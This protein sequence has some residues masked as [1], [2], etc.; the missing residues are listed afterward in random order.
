[1]RVGGIAGVR[2]GGLCAALCEDSGPVRGE[3][4][5]QPPLASR[6]TE[7]GARIRARIVGGFVRGNCAVRVGGIAGVRVRG[8]CAC[9]SVGHCAGCWFIGSLCVLMV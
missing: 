3:Q 2:V 1:M 4:G 5:A 9:G 8:L 6:T 7:D